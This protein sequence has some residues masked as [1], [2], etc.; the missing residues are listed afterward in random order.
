V[1]LLALGLRVVYHSGGR[2]A[3]L[4]AG[5]LLLFVVGLWTVNGWQQTVT[6][7]KTQLRQAVTFVAER[8]QPDQLLILQIPHTHYAWRYYTSDFGGDPFTDG[9]TR[10]APW[11]E[12][13]WTQ[14]GLPD[15]QAR[16]EVDGAMRRITDGY[17]EAWVVLVEAGSWDGRRLMD[18]WLDEH[19]T[20]EETKTFYGIEVRRYRLCNASC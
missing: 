14:N 13:L 6:P 12:G 7:N 2:V 9:E 3:R 1:L 5:L 11:A 17:D 10:L 4:G 15:D 20:Q 8:R 18:G 19:G 16:A